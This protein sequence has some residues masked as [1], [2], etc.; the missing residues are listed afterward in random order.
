M[1]WIQGPSQ[2][3][4]TNMVLHWAT[5][6]QVLLTVEQQYSVP[7]NKP[8]IF[9][10]ESVSGFESQIRTR[11]IPTRTRNLFLPIHEACVKSIRRFG[12]GSTS[13]YIKTIKPAYSGTYTRVSSGKDR[14]QEETSLV[15]RFWMLFTLHSRRREIL[16]GILMKGYFFKEYFYH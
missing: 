9:Q 11:A 10:V 2:N 3:F 5:T 16:K 13:S 12:S 14:S 8:K 7:E 6:R 1:E 15:E 4:Q